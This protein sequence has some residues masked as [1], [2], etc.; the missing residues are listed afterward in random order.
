M[1]EWGKSRLISGEEAA[2]RCQ[3]SPRS[4]A[5]VDAPAWHGRGE[6]VADAF[7]PHAHRGPRGSDSG[8]CRSR[9]CQTLGYALTQAGPKGTIVIGPG[10]YPES[11]SANVVKPGLTGLRIRSAGGRPHGHRRHRQRQ[12]H[13]HPGK[14]GVG[15]RAHRE[16][17]QPR[18]HPG[19]APLSSWPQGPTSAPAN[20]SHLTIAGNAVVHNDRALQQEP[21]AQR[22]CPSSLTDGDDCGE[23]IHLLGVSWSKVFR[24]LVSDNVGGILLSDGGFGISVGPAAHNV[25]A[26]NRSPDNA[27][28]CGVTLPGHDPFA[29]ATSGQTSDRLSLTWPGV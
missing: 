5:P 24:N 26:Y 2:C 1:T 13:P 16:A 28:D 17:R 8:N 10:I 15:H 9:P 6:R 27:F 4:P 3:Q 14:R 21:P 29:V 22:A 7:T 19:R 18:G 11:G 12:R 23:G 20:I 25:I